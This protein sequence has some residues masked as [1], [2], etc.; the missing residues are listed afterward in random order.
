VIV[1]DYH[2]G[3]GVI[4][5]EPC[6]FCYSRNVDLYTDHI[7]CNRCEAHGPVFDRRRW[8]LAVVAWNEIPRLTGDDLTKQFSR[9]R[10][11]LR[12]E[13][14]KKKRYLAQ[15]RKEPVEREYSKWAVDRAAW[16]AR[17]VNENDA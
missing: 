6:P 5:L 4:E 3:E 2:D 10:S 14:E 13:R 7:Q 1:R 12:T 11:R 8:E 9:W 16:L 15:A 17:P